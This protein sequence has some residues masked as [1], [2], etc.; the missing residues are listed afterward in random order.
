[1]TLGQVYDHKVVY[2]LRLLTLL[3][4]SDPIDDWSDRLEFLNKKVG[5]DVKRQN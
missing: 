5:K 2:K 1:M 3:M 4:E